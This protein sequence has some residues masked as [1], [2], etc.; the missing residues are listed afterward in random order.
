MNEIKELGI[1]GEKDLCKLLRESG[2]PV[3]KSDGHIILNDHFCLIE[4]KNK[5]RPWNPPPFWGHGIDKD[6]YDHY[7][8]LY[9]KWNI[10]T[11]LFVPAK[12]E[13]W[14]WN[15]LDDLARGPNHLTPSRILV[16]PFESFKS[17]DE[18]G[19]IVKLSYFMGGRN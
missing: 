1:H 9:K 11:I 12:E 18:L 19:E 3:K 14:I 4:A 16:F 10:R 5:S 13:G 8:D 17:F 15:Y 6:Q 7:M 2:Y